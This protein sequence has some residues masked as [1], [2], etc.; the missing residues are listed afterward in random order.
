MPLDKWNDTVADYPRD[1]CLH[2][3]FEDQVSASPDRIAVVCGNDAITYRELNERAARLADRLVALGIGPD[4]LTAICL[5]RSVEMVVAV[6]GVLKSGG[7]YVPIDPAYPADR[8]AFMLEDA[9]VKAIVSRHSLA[10]TIS[11]PAT[12]TVFIDELTPVVDPPPLYRQPTPRNLAY[13]RYTSG[14]TGKPKGVQ[15]EHRAIVNFITSMRKTPGLSE[16][17]VLLSVTTLSFDI[18]ELEIHLPLTTGACVI[19]STWETATSGP[20]LM[21]SIASHG[22]TIMQATPATWRLMLEAGWAGTPELKV[23]CGGE[24]LSYDLACQLFP[25]CAEL[26]NMYG[27]TETTVW[28]TCCRI[29][30]PVDINIGRPIANTKVYI[31]DANQQL[32]TVGEE[33]ELLI[34]GDGVAR[35]YLNRPDLTA[36]KFIPHPSEPGQRLYR[37]GD[38][39]RFRND[40]TIDCLGRLDFQIKIQGVR[41][42]PGEIEAILTTHPE[43]KQAVVVAQED[44]SGD[45]RLVAYF[46]TSEGKTPSVSELR[47]LVQDRLPPHMVPAAFVPLA[48]IP[49][50]PNGKVDSKALPKP[51]HQRPALG[52]DFIAPNSLMEKQM[53]TLWSV[54]LNI[55]PVG[56]DDSFFELGGTSLKAARLASA[57]Q[58]RYG[59]ELP[60]VKI[61]QYPT[62]AGIVAWLEN[63]NDASVFV[64]E[65]ERRALRSRSAAGNGGRQTHIAIIGMVGRFPGADDLETLWRNL[66]AGVE[67]I[68]VFSREELGVGIDETMRY[69]PDYVPAR[70]IINRIEMFDATFF[71]IG[72]LE[73]SVMDP[74]QRVFLE[75]AYAAL[76]NAG[77]DPDR[78][79]GPVGVYAGAGDNHYYSVNLLGHP[80]LLARAGRL[81]VEYGNEKDY[82]A[83]RV[84]YLLNLTGPAVSSNTACS[85]TLLTVDQAVRSL[86]SFECDMALAGGIDI[87][88][89]QKSGFFYEEGGTFSR[90][91]HCR[92]FDADATGTMFCDGAGIVV[93]K[94]LDDAIAAGDTIYA[95]ISG[96]AKNNNGARTASFL[97]PSIE[98]QAEVVAMAQANADVPVETIGY[99]EAHGTGT[100]V[101]DP[102]EIEALNKVF[103]AKTEK[104]QFCY[105]GSIKGNIGHPTNAAGVAGVIKAALVLHREEIPPTLHFRKANPKIDFEKS[106]FKVPDR[107]I[108]F[109]RIATPRRVAVSSFGFGGTNVHAILEEAPPPK[110][111]GLSRPMHLVAVSARTDTALKAYSDALSEYF[112]SCKDSDFADAAATL[113][114]GRK[115]WPHRRFV[116]AGAA[117]EAITLM[118]KPNPLKSVARHCTRRNPPVVFLFG[119]QGTQYVNMGQNLYQ[120]EPLFRATIDE[121]CEALRPHLGCDLRTIMYPAKHDEETASASLRNTFYTQPAI[122]TIE[123]AL[124]LWWR[125]LGVEPAMMVGHSIGEF[126]AATIAGVFTLPDVLRVVTARGRLMQSMSGGAMLSVRASADEIQSLLPPEIELAAINSPTLCVVSGPAELV[127]SVQPIFESRGWI[128]SELFTSHAFHSHMMEPMLEPLRKELANTT[129]KAPIRPLMSTVTGEPMVPEQACDPDYWARQ[130]RMTVR[131]SAA[132]TWLLDHGYDMFLE[133]GPRATMSTLTRQHALGRPIT[134]IASMGESN[135]ANAESA[136]ILFAL[137]SLWL[138]GITIDWEAFYAHEKRRRIPLPTYPFERQRHWV[139]P[140]A[141]TVGKI[142]PNDQLATIPSAAPEEQTQNQTDNITTTSAESRVG[143][144]MTKLS[145]II[146]QIIGQN[147]ATID[148]ETTF[149]ELGLDSLSLVQVTSTLRREL[150]VKISFS[151]LMNQFPSIAMLSEYL[152]TTLPADSFGAEPAISIVPPADSLSGGPV[153]ANADL[154]RMV[155]EQGRVI[156]L[157]M[158]QMEHRTAQPQNA[159]TVTETVCTPQLPGAEDAVPPEIELPTTVPQRGI[160]LSS[161]LSD[162]LSASYNE[163][164]TIHLTGRIDL[165][166]LTRAIRN[167]VKRHDALR[168]KFDESG[169]FMSLLQVRNVSVDMVDLSGLDANARENQLESLTADETARPFPLPDGPLFRARVMRLDSTRA[170]VVLTGHHTICDGWSLDVLIHDLCAY[171]SAELEGQTAILQPVMSYGEYVRTCATRG[172]SAEFRFARQYYEARFTKMFPTLVLPTIGKRSGMRR[173]ACKQEEVTVPPAIVQSLRA[174]CMHHKCGLF[175]LVLAAYSIF[176]ARISGQCHF[177]IALPIAEQPMLDQPHLVGHCVSMLPFEVNIQSNETV[178]SFIAGV[179]HQLSHAY[180]HEAYTATHLIQRLRP[181]ATYVGIR[182]VSVGLTS[183][184]KWRLSDLPQKGFKVD[185]DVTPRQ[186]ESFEFYLMAIEQQDEL[187]LRCNF[188]CDL[189]DQATVTGWMQEF[190]RLLSALPEKYAMMLQSLV[191]PTVVP[192]APSLSVHYILAAESSDP[193]LNLSTDTEIPTIQTNGTDLTLNAIIQVWQ[194]VLGIGVIG[195]DD[196]FFDLGGHSLLALTLS[197]KVQKTFG[198][199]Y[200]LSALLKAPTPLQ[201]LAL[202]QETKLSTSFHYVVPITTGGNRA[203]VFLFH[204]HGGNVLEYYRLATILGSDRPVYAIQCQ[205]VDGGELPPP[206]IET[207]AQAYLKEI[208]AVQPQ[209]PYVL[210]GYCFGGLLAL[211]TARQLKAASQET[212][213]VVM[214]NAATSEYTQ[215]KVNGVSWLRGMTWRVGDRLALERFDIVGKPLPEKLSHL[216]VR[217]GRMIDLLQ[218]RAERIAAR[219]LTKFDLKMTKHSFVYHLEEL[220]LNNDLAW[221]RYVPHPYDGKVLFFVAGRQSREVIPDRMLGWNGLLTGNVSHHVVQG[222]RQNLLDEPAVFQLADTINRT[223]ADANL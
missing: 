119:G 75:L 148:I 10:R 93:L 105:L 118:R 124:A 220:G 160:F 216:R 19:I 190:A 37:S 172:A 156:A 150:K 151:Q 41:I 219:A 29:T 3:L 215:C 127:A 114:R 193:E 55:E 201:A 89:P 210:A 103:N 85:T 102:I 31:V 73:A 2:E 56:I 92:P 168:A 149:F 30:D 204:S 97:A 26:W 40:G 22:V 196:N 192:S 129:L 214:I 47:A 99:I 194:E 163:S 13:V 136:V 132:A 186:F 183:L 170:D 202:L 182:P 161:R 46:T 111:S 209:G 101:G 32:L 109:P 142:E 222:F 8:I 159:G 66:C 184:K 179:Q 171:Y 1:R 17:D 178:A 177:V 180:D 81:A 90:D 138:Q 108:P 199:K 213:L 18:S 115:Q 104:R 181:A 84:A 11:S 44:I 147:P 217:T 191:M 82:I 59:S 14:S 35:G 86:A 21:A 67:S 112:E 185:F 42:E 175:S 33:G 9:A 158:K 157:L 78:C 58:S 167:L 96:T 143:R 87:S 98:G 70:G 65:Q 23:L 212:G 187:V 7:A 16:I 130:A 164:M 125:S 128:Y 144:I 72:A 80:H 174:F 122:F 95:V 139:D 60:L 91:G 25:R 152:E 77:Y 173:F 49:L 5:D 145:E 76:E 94:R 116:V 71:G 27:P 52:R 57:W 113:L 200:P 123:Y 121:C 155:E 61:F 134:T 53:A 195:P 12:P 117:S 133:C 137:G 34:G 126:V 221:L 50:T 189:F 198:V 88:V 4:V 15:I 83:L 62:V 153:P 154:H 39:A 169:R 36:E 24:A 207:M 43:V 162:N 20:A 107:L 51:T 165:A 131:F 38:L 203:P 188:D 79:P 48:K 100:P 63:R 146:G 223:L 166:C 141:A 6:I 206:L 45:K 54:V 176:L 135:E 110:P 208:R 64:A 197:L 69:D 120:T 28:S 140:I 74:Q 106:C 218:V 68:S 205:G 211:E